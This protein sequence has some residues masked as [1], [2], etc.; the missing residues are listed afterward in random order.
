MEFTSKQLAAI[1][2]MLPQCYRFETKDVRQAH[3]KQRRAEAKLPEAKSGKP[4]SLAKDQLDAISV[5]FEQLYRHPMAGFFKAM[6]EEAL[7]L[8]RLQPQLASYTSTQAF[9][10]DLEHLFTRTAKALTHPD[11]KQMAKELHS[12]AT[13]ALRRQGLVAT[14]EATP[15][16]A[17][18]K[19]RS[20]KPFS[21]A[22]RAQL[23]EKIRRVGAEAVKGLPELLHG[24]AHVQ[25]GE[26]TFNIYDLPHKLCR[27]LLAL[28][29]QAAKLPPQ[30]PK[31]VEPAVAA[32]APA[33]SDSESSSSDS[34][35]SEEAALL[36]AA[37]PRPEIPSIVNIY[38]QF[39]EAQ[40]EDRCVPEFGSMMDSF[41]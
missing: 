3:A 21:V 38:E 29:N 17:P 41:K 23:F 37:K 6:P 39:K 33:T 27:E 8:N 36:P 7:D 1:N 13:E 2:A 26:L 11:C 35:Q 12:V 10:Q 25:N 14:E 31:K 30:R 9:V 40:D 18:H 16:V 20:E 34:D 4:A 24:Y 5:V 32:A 15:A 19:P 22:E 28:V